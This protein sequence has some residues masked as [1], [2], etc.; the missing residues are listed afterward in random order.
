[1]KKPFN[2][3]RKKKAPTLTGL[4][5][6]IRG[7]TPGLAV[8]MAECCHPLPGERIVGIMTEGRGIDVH[9]IDCARLRRLLRAAGT[10]AGLVLG[11]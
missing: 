11:E 5:I 1:M 10:L 4:P 8:H 9:T 6:P 7:L 2:L 3:Q